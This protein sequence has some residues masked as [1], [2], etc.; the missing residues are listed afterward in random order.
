LLRRK[1][2]SKKDGYKGAPEFFVGGGGLGGPQPA[3]PTAANK[4][5]KAARRLAK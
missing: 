2:Q 3:Q 1:K 4:K 5:L